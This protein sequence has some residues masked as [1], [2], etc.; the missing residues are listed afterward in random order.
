MK[1][2][3][4][5]MITA[6]MMS[7]GLVAFTGSSAQA[8]RCPYTGCINTATTTSGP[9]GVKNG[10]STRVKVRVAAAGNA[11]PNGKLIIVVRKQGKGKIRTKTSVY[12]GTPTV[13]NTGRLFG[14]GNYKVIVK[15]KPGPTDPFRKSRGIHL[16]RVR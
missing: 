15:Y 1:K 7:S 13:V 11:R 9:Y 16:L 10:R 3:F 5:I 6:F 8:A 2:I 12:R 4:A 14:K